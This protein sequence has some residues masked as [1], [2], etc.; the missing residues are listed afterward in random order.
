MKKKNNNSRQPQAQTKKTMQEPIFLEITQQSAIPKINIKTVLTAM[1]NEDI[2]ELIPVYN[3]FLKR[4]LHLAAEMMKRRGQLVSLPWSIKSDDKNTKELLEGYLNTIDFGSLIM[5]ISTGIGYGFSCV[6]MVY[7]AVDQVFAPFEFHLIHQRYFEYY[8]R[9]RLLR[10]RENSGVKTDP[11]IAPDKF[12][13]HFH[14]S[15]GGELV[16]FGVIGQVIF[17][18]LLKHAAITSN[19]QYFE[20]L[21]VPPII[22]KTDS[23]TDEELRSMLNQIMSLR[24]NAIGM[25]PKDSVVEL[26]EGKASKT[27]FLDFIRYCDSAISHYIIGSTLSGG[28]DQTGSYALGKVHDERRK[29]IMRLDAR[30]LEKTI[31]Q[32]LSRVLALNTASPK[33]FKFTFDI[34][35][36]TDEKLLSEVYKNLSDAGFDIPPEHISKMFSIE[37]VTRKSAV[38]PKSQNAKEFNNTVHPQSVPPFRIEDEAH[39]ID[40]RKIERNLKSQLE[41]ILAE[42]GDYDE[43]MLFLI[44]AYPDM[45]FDTLATMIEESVAKSTIIGAVEVVS[46]G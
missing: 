22:V 32:L 24:S 25:F 40:T 34:G 36:E 9:D 4:D 12:I 31:N 30:L 7:S 29:D 14:K 18:A 27:D 19:M 16:D 5:D 15:D 42:A 2:G 17:T 26:L 33:P 8:V 23:S 37:G 13:L 41:T 45:S 3:A 21:G 1:A 10:F 46:G 43:A 35:D 44:E 20:T 39:A 6:D 38:A 11:S 28:K